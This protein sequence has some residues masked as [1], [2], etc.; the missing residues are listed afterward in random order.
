MSS[1]A[2]PATYND[3]KLP[4]VGVTFQW[5]LPETVDET[6]KQLVRNENFVNYIEETNKRLVNNP[7]KAIDI[8]QKYNKYIK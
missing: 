5:F 6:I 8:S 4:S 2:L 7:S 3:L 1:L